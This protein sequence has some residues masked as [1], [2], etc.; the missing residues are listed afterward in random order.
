MIGERHFFFMSRSIRPARGALE[1]GSPL[2]RHAAVIAAPLDELLEVA[3]QGGLEDAKSELALRR[4][5]EIL[6]A[7]E[8]A[9]L[10]RASAW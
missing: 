10:D 6:A 3:R 7:K 9:K 1:D 5:K 2:E 4:L 8:G